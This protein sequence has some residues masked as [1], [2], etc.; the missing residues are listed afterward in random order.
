M[1]RKQLQQSLQD[2]SGEELLA[3]RLDY[4]N[5]IQA[6]VNSEL[7]RRARSRQI[8][9]LPLRVFSRRMVRR[10]LVAAI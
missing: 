2:L 6:V 5:E 3:L 7:D 1:N 8:A 9:S 10:K 4:G